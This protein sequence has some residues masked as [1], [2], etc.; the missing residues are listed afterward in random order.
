MDSKASGVLLGAIPP[1]TTSSSYTGPGTYHVG[2]LIYPTGTPA[3]TLQNGETVG[4]M[5]DLDARTISFMVRCGAPVMSADVLPGGVLSPFTEGQN[6][7]IVTLN[8]G[9]SSFKCTVPAG[10]NKGV[11]Q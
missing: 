6:G 1:S 3:P 4:V 9:A 7:S 2:G 5:L 8:F 10:F 11:W